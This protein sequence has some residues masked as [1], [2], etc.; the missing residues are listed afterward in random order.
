MK[1]KY[2]I[3]AIGAARKI[4]GEPSPFFPGVVKRVSL[5][6]AQ[7]AAARPEHFKVIEQLPGAIEKPAEET[8]SAE[9]TEAKE[10]DSG[11]EDTGSGADEAGEDDFEAKEI[12]EDW[13][14]QLTEF[15]K[16]TLTKGQVDDYLDKV[17]H[18]PFLEFLV[19]KAEKKGAVDAARWR[20]EQI[21][22]KA[23]E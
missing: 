19:M 23:N 20:I 6:T 4:D 5:E 11:T 14:K 3:T 7:K 13:E 15:N 2:R 8:T 22:E 10:E 9:D 17:T 18:I 12:P 16:L 1:E 21:Q